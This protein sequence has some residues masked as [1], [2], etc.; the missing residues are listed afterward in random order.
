MPIWEFL[1]TYWPLLWSGTL[2]TC[3]QF[4]LASVIAVA[5]ALLAGLGKLSGNWLIKGISVI[6]I[7]IF[8][9]TSLLVQLYWIFFVLPLLGL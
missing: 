4:V 5:C 3:G 2:I 1:Q 9:G 8:R 6:Y 7:E